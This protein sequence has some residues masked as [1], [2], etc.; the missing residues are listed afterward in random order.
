MF[1]SSIDS[2]G[3]SSALAY[4]RQ[5]VLGSTPRE[6]TFAVVLSVSRNPNS[7]IQLLHTSRLSSVFR[8]ISVPNEALKDVCEL[9]SKVHQEMEELIGQGQSGDG[10]LRW[11]RN[12]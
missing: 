6:G 8:R 4:M 1:V 12:K 10:V 7:T 11:L 9:A 5:K 3:H 2:R